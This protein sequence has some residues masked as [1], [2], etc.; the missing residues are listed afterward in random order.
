MP[1]KTGKVVHEEG[2][3]SVAR[4][5]ERQEDGSYV[6]AGFSLIGSDIDPSIRYSRLQDALVTIDRLLGR[7]SAKAIG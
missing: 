3:F 5:M 6:P 1:F 7:P 2:G 4:Y